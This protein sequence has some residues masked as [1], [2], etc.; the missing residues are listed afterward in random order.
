MSKSA[1]IKCFGYVGDTIFASSI[2]QKLKEE[3]QFDRIDYVIGMPQCRIL[4]EQ[5]PYI[6]N[7]IITGAH[8]QPVY[9]GDGIY[10]QQF[11][12]GPLSLTEPP[13]MEMQ[14]V[15]GVRN[16]SPEYTVYTSPKFDE[17]AKESVP[18]RTVAIMEPNSW[19]EKAFR[20]T[21]EEYERGIDVP[22]LGYGGE[23]R[24]IDRIVN[25]LD[26]LFDVVAVGFPPDE[27]SLVI[28]QSDPDAG[29][30]RLAWTASVLKRC[31]AFVG[32]EGGLA[33]IAAGVGTPCLLTGEYV[34]QLYGWNGVMRQM[35][36]PQLGPHLYF[37][38]GGH[39]MLDPYLTDDE[40]IGHL[41]ELLGNC[42]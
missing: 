36:D 20:F 11:Q 33:N 25:E 29:A 26:Q 18:L 16:P 27:N 35:K 9:N 32:T 39:T 24:Q 15:C 28:A 40:V 42:L 38:D 4:L 41:I 7:V 37:P 21:K 10:D 3:N 13:P 8:P 14:R 31:A 34:H 19:L 2:A 5:N 22:Y 6:D 23:L 30:R 12:L 1:L 17:K